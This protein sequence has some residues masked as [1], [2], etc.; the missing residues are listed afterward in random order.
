MDFSWSEEQLEFR[1]AAV[2]FARKEL[3]TGLTERDKGSEF[4]RE[5][6]Q[7]CAQF[8]IL[9]MPFAEEYG[10]LGG[11]ILTT[12]LTMEGLGYGCRDNGLVFSINAQ[13]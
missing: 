1:G 5:N 12:M 6:W 4:S 3:N 2:E 9:G 8:G 11:D 10:G 7:K 13:M